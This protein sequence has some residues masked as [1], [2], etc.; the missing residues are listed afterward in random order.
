MREHG[1]GL[2]A[3]QALRAVASLVVL[4]GL[5][6]GRAKGDHVVLQVEEMEGPWRRQTNIRGYEGQGFCTSNANPK[7]ADTRMRGTVVVRAPGRH[8]VWVRGFTSANSRRAFQVEVNGT[9]LGKTHAGRMRRWVWERA[10][11]VDLPGGEV[12]VV[13]HDADVGFESADAVLLSDRKGFDPMDEERAW[14]VFGDSL[15]E[16]ADALRH[17]IEASCKMLAQRRPPASRE[18]WESDRPRLRRDLL[19]ALGLASLPERTPLNARVTGRA[20]CAAYTVENVVF[21][22]RPTF[23]VTA[24]LY[25]P[26]AVPLPAPAVVVTMGH[27]MEESKNY[28][29]YHAAQVSLARLGYVVLGFDPIGQ[30]ERRV[31]GQG[32]HLAYGCVLVGQTM[33]GMMVWDAMRAVDY[34]LTRAEVDP[35]RIGLTGN[36]GGGMNTFYAMPVDERIAAGASF[37]F[38]CSYFDWVRDG[39]NHCI[40]NHLPGVFQRLE[41]FEILA[42]RGPRPI[43]VGS[44]AKDPIFPIRGTRQAVAHARTIYGFSGAEDAVELVETPEGHG[45]SQPLREAAYGWFGRW[46]QGRES[47]DAIP[48]PATSADEPEGED[49]LCFKGGEGMPKD[50][51]TVVSLNR[52]VAEKLIGRYSGTPVSPE[53]WRGQAERLRMGL[54]DVLGGEP[55]AFVPAARMVRASSWR[56]H[57]IESLALGIE[58]GLEV[59]AVMVRPAGAEGRV[60]VVVFLDAK[61]KALVAHSPLALRLLDSGV[62][63]LALDPR[64]MGETAVHE[65]QLTSDTI[66]LGRHLFGQRVWDVMQAVRYLS[67]RDDVDVDAIRFYGA[68][69]CGLLGLAAAALGAPF[70]RLAMED[71]LAS[72][73]FALE[74]GQPQPI[75]VF[76]PRLLTVADIPQITAAVAPVPILWANPVG[77]GREGLVDGDA[78]T[79]LAFASHAYELVGHGDAFGI[80]VG[81]SD[82]T[83]GRLADFLGR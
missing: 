43:L 69:A 1:A 35:E 71:A 57:A 77:Y 26:K 60:P 63:V 23:Y 12:R 74:N 82:E 32:H 47:H 25:V 80:T 4:A 70:E 17:T 44:G 59:A 75:W 83:V 14:L 28:H 41:E 22:S 50:A 18:Q 6:H 38:V 46:L 81:A 27:A 61:D 67:G 58:P 10:G 42:L 72:Y 76:V 66:C 48:E 2:P 64:G 78:R 20:E 37:C 31:P 56:G 54:W 29:L 39:G 36:S 34:L 15:P 45:W 68:E 30:G 52:A 13:V 55:G 53:A 5:L 16:E 21:E 7:I 73:R 65:N 33:E 49:L 8:A 9:L 3:A 40:C 79:A 51:E 24:N 11:Q 62:A 19:E